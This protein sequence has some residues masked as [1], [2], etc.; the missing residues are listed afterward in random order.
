MDETKID[1]E[2]L[3]KLDAKALL[4]FEQELRERVA[5][6]AQEHEEPKKKKRRRSRSGRK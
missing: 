1:Y 4:E 5:R 2:S 3:S 6:E